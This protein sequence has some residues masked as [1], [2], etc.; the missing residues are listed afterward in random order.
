MNL[1]VSKTAEKRKRF[2]LVLLLIVVGLILL[3]PT[4]QAAGLTKATE[5]NGYAYSEY[6]DSHYQLDYYVDDSGVFSFFS[7][8]VASS[9]FMIVSA[10][11]NLSKTVSTLT[12]NIVTEAYTLDFVKDF[13]HGIGKNMQSIAGVNSSGVG[14]T[15]LFPGFLVMIVLIVGVYVAYHGL[16]KRST[17]KALSA[18]FNLIVVFVLSVGFLA[19]APQYMENVTDFSSDINTT[20]LSIGTKLV[21]P[22]TKVQGQDETELIVNSLWGVQVKQPWLILQFGSTSVD[23]ERVDALVSADP[24]SDDREAAVKNEVTNHN[25]YNLISKRL[26]ARFGNVLLIMIVNLAMSIFVLLLMGTM[27]F[28]QLIF[29]VYATLMPFVLVFGMLPGAD[30]KVMKMLIKM[31]NLLL[32]RAAIGLIVTIAFSLSSMACSITANTYFLFI[33]F[34]QIVIFAGIYMN[35]SKFLGVVSLN[36]DASK[37]GAR[38]MYQ[39]GTQMPRQ[40]KRGVHTVKDSVKSA[41]SPFTQIVR[42]AK[43]DSNANGKNDS[44]GSSSRP[45]SEREETS[46]GKQPESE[47]NSRKTGNRRAAKDERTEVTD[48]EQKL[49]D[50]NKRTGAAADREQKR[51]DEN[52]RTGETD[53]E[54]KRTDESKRTGAS[55]REQKRTDG[56]KHTGT[57]DREQ[58][59]G[60]ENNRTGTPDHEQS[61]TGTTDREQS[62]TDDSN[63]KT[64]EHERGHGDNGSSSIGS[65][66]SS[67]R[68]SAFAND[69]PSKPT[70]LDGTVK[71]NGA[72]YSRE[73]FRNSDVMDVSAKK[74]KNERRER[75][76]ERAGKRRGDS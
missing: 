3:S 38:Q 49:T 71:I 10:F 16:I 65:Y 31:F 20:M 52:K 1:A 26:N 64:S 45:S 54:Q 28:S 69:S 21:F 9:G 24:D 62:R 17:S 32:T 19:Y 15:G 68:D 56:N 44:S 30:G 47:N 37:Q 36:I 12:G 57:A 23:E 13:A 59:R 14:G 11:W 67:G 29:I 33:A 48:Q 63:F 76:P 6:D 70:G 60:D 2:V 55:D 7:D 75:R 72:A 66:S 42:A 43:G 27:L 39:K 51:T 8:T 40:L 74:N 73:K 4:A 25:N 50:E 58:Q 46:D 53:Q 22:D 18:V 41:V 61:H 34:L 35:M 5:S